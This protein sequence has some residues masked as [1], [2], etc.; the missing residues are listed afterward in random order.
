MNFA[1]IE[2][3]LVSTCTA[4]ATNEHRQAEWLRFSDV[5]P[6]L[7]SSAQEM[8]PVYASAYG[9]YIYSVF[10]PIDRLVGNYINDLLRWNFSPSSGWG[11]GTVNRGPEKENEPILYPP[12]DRTDSK[13]LDNSDPLFFLRYFDGRPNKKSYV[14]INQGFAHIA[15]VHWVSARK[16]YC[17]IDQNGDFDEVVKIQEGEKGFICAVKLPALELYMFVTSTVLIRVFDFPRSLRDWSL[18]KKSREKR[19]L[20]DKKAE[21]YANRILVKG[22]SEKVDASLLRGVQIIRNQQPSLKSIEMSLGGSIAPHQYETFIIWDWKNKQVREWSCDSKGLSNYFEQ[23]DLPYF[24]SPVFF[25]PEVLSKYK[26]DPEKYTVDQRHISCR[27][28]WSLQTYDINDEGQVH[29]YVGYLG[30]L[31]HQEQLYW[32]AFNENPKGGLSTRALTT[33][34]MGQFYTEPDPLEE[35]KQCLL[36]FPHASHSGE[37]TPIWSAPGT[38]V[39]KSLKKIHY[40]IT[41]SQKEWSDQVLELAKVIIDGLNKTSIRRLAKTLKCDNPGLGSIKLL[42]ACLRARGIEEDIVKEVCDPLIRLQEMRSK[43]SAHGG[44]QIPNCNLKKDHQERLAEVSQAM[45]LFAQLIER[46]V[47]NFANSAR[48]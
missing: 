16:A 2:K 32:K 4:P 36:K 8:V 23:S 17:R 11:Y 35:L 33:D 15:G 29:T 48:L 10:V 9:V 24:T 28:A 26:Q 38:D 7:K 1:A 47:M 22:P 19:I 40:V 42:C 12:L 45:K 34:F 21:I 20:R 37:K 27:G 30:H 18:P 43:C 39:E 44:G 14:E 13:V 3:Y 31:P 25:R 46:G 5:I 6:F 41:D